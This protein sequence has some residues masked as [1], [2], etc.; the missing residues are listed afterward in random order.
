MEALTFNLV[1]VDLNHNNI[2]RGQLNAS[3]LAVSEP[4]T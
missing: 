1:L 3:K 2:Y 4:L